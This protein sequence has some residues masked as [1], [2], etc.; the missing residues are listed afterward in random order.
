MGM[1]FSSLSCY[2]MVFLASGKLNK[3]P[4]KHAD[5]L[6]FFAS[7]HCSM[8]SIE[9]LRQLKH[10]RIMLQVYQ[11]TSY[12]LPK[13]LTSL[14]ITKY[15][16]LVA[17]SCTFFSILYLLIQNETSIRTRSLLCIFTR[18]NIFLLVFTKG[19]IC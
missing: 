17:Q 15:T 5:L 2:Q 1:L 12:S 14:N 6:K 4:Q 7:I 16:V 9:S 18:K 19:A 11:S 10:M 8:F 13:L 3:D